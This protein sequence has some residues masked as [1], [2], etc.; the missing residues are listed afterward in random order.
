M[1][2]E[3]LSLLVELNKIQVAAGTAVTQGTK[4]VDG[5]ANV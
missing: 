2:V 5:N 4:R 3:M 1:S